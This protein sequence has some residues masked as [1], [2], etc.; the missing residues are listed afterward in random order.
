VLL[1]F[2]L[3]SQQTPLTIQGTVLTGRRETAD[4][5][6]TVLDVQ[7]KNLPTADQARIKA[8]ALQ[9]LPHPEDRS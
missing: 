9:T 1:V 7:F 6:F 8:W 5:P 4:K 2:S 3:P